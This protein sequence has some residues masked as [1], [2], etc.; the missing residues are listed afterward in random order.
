VCVHL[1][2]AAAIP[3]GG[4]LPFQEIVFVNASAMSSTDAAAAA[5]DAAA[6]EQAAT[7][8]ASSTSD[9]AVVVSPVDATGKVDITMFDFYDKRTVL[10]GPRSAGPTEKS[11]RRV[12]GS[13]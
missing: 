8:S 7:P 1:G 10:S 13:W 3:S 11:N 2:R 12:G 9:A 5:L 6:S 4:M